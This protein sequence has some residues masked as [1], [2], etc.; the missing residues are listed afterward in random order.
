MSS[1]SMI[2]SNVTAAVKSWLLS[3]YRNE[4]QAL[5]K[6]GEQSLDVDST[7]REV[8]A[9]MNVSALIERTLGRIDVILAALGYDPDELDADLV[10]PWMLTASS[11]H[12]A[13]LFD[14]EVEELNVVFLQYNAHKLSVKASEAL[15]KLMLE[16]STH[17]THEKPLKRP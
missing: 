12:Y 2:E 15:S 7:R 13:I 1:T 8:F 6:L 11:Y 16:V 17:G 5:A 4:L 3:A 10:I 14:K 9:R